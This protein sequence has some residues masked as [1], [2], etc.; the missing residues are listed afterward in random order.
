MPSGPLIRPIWSVIARVVCTRTHGTAAITAQYSLIEGL[1]VTAGL[2]GHA[3]MLPAGI[4]VDLLEVPTFAKWADGT[5][6]D[7][8]AP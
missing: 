8:P 6:P 7:G 3:R 2:R 1:Q 4:A 5:R